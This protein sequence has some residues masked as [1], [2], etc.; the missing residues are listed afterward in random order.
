VLRRLSLIIALVSFGALVSAGSASA[1]T[2]TTNCANLQSTLD[3]AT[4]AGDTVILTE[5][6]E[7]QSYTLPPTTNNLTIEGR[8]FLAAGPGGTA[9]YEHAGFD[10]LGISTS[11]ALTS[12]SGANGVT[13]RNLQF[14]G[15]AS[16]AVHILS[17]TSTNPYMIDGVD[18]VQNHDTTPFTGGALYLNVNAPGACPPAGLPITITN[19]QFRGNTSPG[20]PG[21]GSGGEG[22]GAGAHISL[23]C[24]N[25]GAGVPT[26]NLSNNIFSGN[27]LNAPSG[28][29][30]QG[31][32]LWVSA[33]GSTSAK[34]IELTQSNNLFFNN[35][36][37]GSGTD[38]AGGGEFTE[39]AN[40]TST[41]DRFVGNE[42][43]GPSV[44]TVQSEGAGLA[45]R[46]GGTCTAPGTTS[47]TMTNAVFARNTLVA[48]SGTGTGGEG[49]GIYAGCTVGTGGY[50]LTLLNSTV[51]ANIAAGPGAVAG[52]DGEA[53]DHLHLLNSIL[54]ANPGGDDLSGFGA[55]A[56][57]NADAAYSDVCTPGSTSPFAGPG[58]ICANP[59]L[60]FGIGN[61][62]PNGSV[63]GDVR[64]TP[65][66]PT[67]DRGFNGFVS[68]TTDVFGGPRILP[69]KPGDS[70]IVDI[71]AAELKLPSNGFSIVGVRG[72]TLIVNLDS[73]G[74]VDVTQAGASSS[75]AVE[76][77]KKKKS[78]L[79]LKPSSGSGGPGQVSIP[80]LLTKKGK[81]KLKRKG[82]VKIAS[83]IKFTPNG[84][85]ANDRGTTLQIKGKKKKKKNK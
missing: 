32:G 45:T 9:G 81:Q 76:A 72:K 58:N 37:H 74:K 17:L 14:A 21:G 83:T 80:L 15:Y 50:D 77:K 8:D 56:G 60:A 59:A 38:F 84:G 40:L 82:K 3:G 53:T 65:S 31:A 27:G 2:F 68:V 24:T 12:N 54:T 29:P 5:L 63:H 85:E 1:T 23:G 67:L 4:G 22:G 7:A 28:Q 18:F 62:D 49:A 66:S 55:S 61:L 25:A 16:E 30:R 6:C 48:P 57:A 78:K 19:S 70:P 51:T 26:V 52:A 44:N 75:R 79:L 10:G 20:A 11:P 35:T 42:L 36:V 71:G 34:P 41:N 46:N 47:S 69:G 39:G 64:E 43:P 73:P 33:A 13:L